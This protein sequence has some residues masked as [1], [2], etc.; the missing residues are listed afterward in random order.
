MTYH[1]GYYKKIKTDV[2]EGAKKQY[3]YVQQTES[4]LWRHRWLI[5]VIILLVVGYYIW[6]KDQEGS[7]GGSV[8]VSASEIIPSSNGNAIRALVGG[9]LN[10]LTP[11]PLSFF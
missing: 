7:N 6:K 4:F 5:L 2:E 10:Y 11:Q 9:D 8:T 3:K 1:S